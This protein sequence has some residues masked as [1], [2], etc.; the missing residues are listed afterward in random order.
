VEKKSQSKRKVSGRRSSKKRKPNTPLYR[1]CSRRD[2]PQPHQETAERHQKLVYLVCNRLWRSTPLVKRLGDLD[3]VYSVGHEALHRA[4][5]GYDAALG[6][7]F[8]TYCCQVVRRYVIEAAL[9]AGIIATP[10]CV[11]RDLFRWNGEGVLSSTD[12]ERLQ[13]CANAL[14]VISITNEK[15]EYNIKEPSFVE[16]HELY[17][18]LHDAIDRLPRAYRVYIL[19]R[20]GLDGQPALS[21]QELRFL[22]WPTLGRNGIYYKEHLHI[23]VDAQD[24]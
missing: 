3:D 15:G 19:K 4:V 1:D 23:S 18:E 11:A 2:S 21:P 5:R 6:F 14:N 12:P 24:L 20:F 22:I 13:K 9:K 16:R 10:R 17:P 7:K 8:S